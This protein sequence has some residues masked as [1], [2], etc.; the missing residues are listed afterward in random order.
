MFW[1]NWEV[2]YLKVTYAS[3]VQNYISLEVSSDGKKL[4]SK[5][6]EQK[7]SSDSVDMSGMASSLSSYTA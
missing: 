3:K 7:V 6:L 4:Q 1:I 2:N 5:Y